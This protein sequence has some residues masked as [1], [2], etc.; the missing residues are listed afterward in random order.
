MIRSSVDHLEDIRSS[1]DDILTFV[2]GYTYE[3]FEDDKKTQ[4]AVIRALEVIGEASKNVSSDVRSQYPSVPWR[5]MASMRDRL[6]HA[7]FGVDTRIV[8]DTIQQDLPSLG[9]SISL[10]LNDL[11]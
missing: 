3:R 5:E 1:I 11:D 2:E 6:I 7:Y 8:W 4:Y 9:S 10:I